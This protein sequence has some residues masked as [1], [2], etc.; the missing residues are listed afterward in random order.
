MIV[1]A[2]GSRRFG[3]KVKCA[4]ALPF[5]QGAAGAASG[6]WASVGRRD[7]QTSAHWMSM[8]ALYGEVESQYEAFAY[9]KSQKE[10]I[11]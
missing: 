3:T 7:G 9:L 6:W 8:K 2:V 10:K 11:R 1:A 5:G 4:A